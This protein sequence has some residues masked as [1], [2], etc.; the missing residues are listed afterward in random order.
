MRAQ[1][2]PHLMGGSLKTA[3]AD[4]IKKELTA[5]GGHR[6]DSAHALGISVRTLEKWLRTWAELKDVVQGIATV[7]ATA[8]TQT[9]SKKKKKKKGMKCSNKKSSSK[10]SEARVA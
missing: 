3:M 7:L 1:Q 5:H 9:K 2:R 4:Q 10:S 6:S 8:G